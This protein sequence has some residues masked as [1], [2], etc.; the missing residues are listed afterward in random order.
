MERKQQFFFDQKSL[1]S[2]ERKRKQQ[3]K[4]MR[5][6]Q[7]RERQGER[8]REREREGGRKGGRERE[9]VGGREGG[10]KGERERERE[11]QSTHYIYMYNLYLSLSFSNPLLQVLFFLILRN[12][13]YFPPLLKLLP[14]NH[15]H[16]LSQEGRAGSVWAALKWR[17]ILSLPS[18]TMCVCVWGGGGG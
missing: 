4:L 8:E 11:N 17:N 15:A 10:R 6:G 2:A 7:K 1:D 3:E 9:R 18:A 5:R 14:R 13:H 16:F 12:L